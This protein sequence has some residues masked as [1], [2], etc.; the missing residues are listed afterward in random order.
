MSVHTK[1]KESTAT[2]YEEILVQ[3]GGFGPYQIRIFILVSLFETP[4]AWVM[5]LPVL[6]GASSKWTCPGDNMTVSNVS[7]RF[8]QNASE[9]VICPDIQY[10]A[11]YTSIITQVTK[12]M[13]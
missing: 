9:C 3:S 8:G 6:T 10:T 13:L 5:L 7:Q 4:V 1:S 11:P 12:D 2:E